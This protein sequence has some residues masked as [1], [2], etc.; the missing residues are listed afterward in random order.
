[1]MDSPMK[2]IIANLHPLFF[3]PPRAR[4]PDGGTGPYERSAIWHGPRPNTVLRP[5]SQRSP[6]LSANGGPKWFR[7]GEG[8]QRH[9]RLASD[10]AMN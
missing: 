8:D 1:M 6:S 7:R 4:R 9:G 3:F 10:A 2:A 5:T